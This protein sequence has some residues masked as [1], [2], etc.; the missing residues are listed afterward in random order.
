MLLEWLKFALAQKNRPH[1][2]SRFYFFKILSQSYCPTIKM[3]LLK[4]NL[5][6][7]QNPLKTGLSTK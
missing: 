5:P 7:S 4:T 2:C 3:A 6:L 1:S